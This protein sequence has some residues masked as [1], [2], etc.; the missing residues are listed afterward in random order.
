MIEY[1]VTYAGETARS[2]DIYIVQRPDIPAPEINRDQIDIP[3]RDGSLYLSQRTVNDIQISIEMNFMTTPDQWGE[4]YREAKAWLLKEQ[5]GVLKMNDDPEWFYRAKKVVIE[6]SERTCRQIGKFI[7]TFT[8]SG[9]M[10]RVDGAT[11]HTIEEVQRNNWEECHPTYL[12]KGDANCRLK[13]NGKYFVVNVGQ[14]C[15]I[16]TERQIAYKSDG[17]L[18]NAYV[19]GD[20]EDLY[21]KTGGNTIEITPETMTMEIIPN[22]RCY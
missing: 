22:W 9:Y 5:N 6:T 21:L 15:T 19:T 7:A 10:Y 13:V 4:K 17:T 3:G 11:S 20:Y 8:C 12:I 18:V 1:D 14:E 2:H 16:D